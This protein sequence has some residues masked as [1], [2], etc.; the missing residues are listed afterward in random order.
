MQIVFSLFLAF[1]MAVPVPDPKPVAESEHI[2]YYVELEE[3]ETTTQV[4]FLEYHAYD[5]APEFSVHFNETNHF[6]D[7]NEHESTEVPELYV[8]LEDILDDLDIPSE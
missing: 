6:E 5:E 2:E 7:Y 4:E 8:S 3:A 1:A